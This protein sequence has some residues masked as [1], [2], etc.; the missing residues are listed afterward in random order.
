M[1]DGCTFLYERKICN[2]IG[3]IKG[4]ATS[5][6]S[7]IIS[8]FFSNLKD[9]YGGIIFQNKCLIKNIADLKRHLV[10]RIESCCYNVWSK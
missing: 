3:L 4:V 10:I 9:M 6:S 8:N 7:F 1:S 5:L 2:W